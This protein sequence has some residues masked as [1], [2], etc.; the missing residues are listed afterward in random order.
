M[1]PAARVFKVIFLVVILQCISKLAT[2]FNSDLFEGQKWEINSVVYD[3][4]PSKIQVLAK[5]EQ[6]RLKHINRK[7]YR[8]IDG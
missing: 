3:V 2:R 8:K 7:M 5:E 6:T 1:D 4:P